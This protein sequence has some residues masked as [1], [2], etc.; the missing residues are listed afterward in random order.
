MAF[1]RSVQIAQKYN[2][3]LGNVTIIHPFHPLSGQSYTVLKIKEVNGK[4]LYSLR[5]DSGV[6]CIPESWTDRQLQPKLNIDTYMVPFDAFTLKGLTQLI[7]D[8]EDFSIVSSN[9]VDKSE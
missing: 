9:T 2:G 7:R 6:I 1:P 3:L 4:R 8:M 5:T